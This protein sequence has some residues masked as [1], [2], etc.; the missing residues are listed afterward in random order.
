MNKNGTVERYSLSRHVK[1]QISK[2]CKNIYLLLMLQ[3]VVI[4]YK[5]YNAKKSS[6][7]S[8]FVEKIMAENYSPNLFNIIDVDDANMYF[9]KTTYQIIFPF[10]YI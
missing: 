6:S 2:D 4:N 1:I 7:I 9:F 5:L 3:K 8:V 10:I